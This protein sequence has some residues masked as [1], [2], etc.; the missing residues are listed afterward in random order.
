M[1][2][3]KLKEL[4]AEITQHPYSEKTQSL[5]IAFVNLLMKKD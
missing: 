1:I 3:D 2:F 4:K 5:K